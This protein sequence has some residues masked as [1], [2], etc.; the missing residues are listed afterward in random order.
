L[1]KRLDQGDNRG[2]RRTHVV[3]RSSPRGCS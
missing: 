1:E 2:S 3:G